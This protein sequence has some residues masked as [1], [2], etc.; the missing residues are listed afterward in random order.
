MAFLQ[1]AW[2]IVLFFVLTLF[3]VLWVGF[4][5][6]NIKGGVSMLEEIKTWGDV[7]ISKYK[8]DNGLTVLLAVEKKSPVFAYYTY[9]NVGSRHEEEGKTG[10]AHFFEHLLFK[11]SKNLKEG[12]FDRLMEENGAQTNASTWVDWTNYYQV[13]PVDAEK[14][15]L[16]VRLEA[17]RLQNMQINEKQVTSEMGVVQNERRFRVDNDIDGTMNEAL[18][19]LA[20]EKHPYGRPIIGW[21]EDITKYNVQDCLAFYNTYYAPNNATIVIAGNIDPRKTM[22]LIQKYY[23]EIPASQIPEKEIPIEPSQTKE[24]RK[25]ISRSD[26]EAEKA[27][28][29]YHATAYDHPD[30]P[31]IELLSEIL[32]NGEGA[33]LYKQMIIEEEIASEV[34]A[35]FGHLK[36]PALFQISVSM[37]KRQPIQKA[38]NRIFAEFK[39]V[40]KEGVTQQELD[41]A[42]NRFEMSYYGSLGTVGGKARALGQYDVVFGDYKKAVKLMDRYQSVTLEDIQRVSQKYFVAS[43]RSIVEARPKR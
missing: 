9:F 25:K 42:K 31:A 23:G 22:T 34:N 24:K 6:K 11:E 19:R 35:W 2:F 37:R 26:I 17:E 27:L 5:G 30:T 16:V 39:K 28:Y 7:H 29:A 3:L 1:R 12:E 21:M 36:D 13:L 43:N 8:L 14:I 4:F 41:R 20:Y 10:L 33:R 15:E 32:F 40:Q 18:N 38:H